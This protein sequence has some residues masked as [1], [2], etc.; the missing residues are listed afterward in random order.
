[1]EKTSHKNILRN[2][3]VGMN[4]CGNKIVSATKFIDFF[5]HDILD[6]TMMNKDSN[7]FIKDHSIFDIRACVDEIITI[8]EDKIAMKT[9]KVSKNFIGFERPI[10]KTDQ[11][12]L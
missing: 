2:I 10:V 3:H 5:V 1:M 11:K 7:K 9:I 6:Y 8:Q 4:I 12:R